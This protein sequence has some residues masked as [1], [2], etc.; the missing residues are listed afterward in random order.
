MTLADE[1]NDDVA[2]AFGWDTLRPDQLDA[3]TAL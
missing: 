1:L 3:I 2:A